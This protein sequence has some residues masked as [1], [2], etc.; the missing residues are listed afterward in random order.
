ML[1]S[2]GDRLGHY[3]VLAHAGA[4]GMGEVYKARDMRLDRTVAIKVLNQ[5]IQRFERE[6]RTV[7]SLNH[8]HICVLHDIGS[9]NGSSYM[10]MEFLEGETLAARIKR[11]RVPLDDALKFAIQIGDALDR[12][13][14][15]GVTHRDI[16][17]GNIMLTRDGAKVLD[18][19]LAKASDAKPT[20]NE[21]TLT[22]AI[23]TEGTVVGTPQYMAPELFE[24]RPA[25]ARSDIWA[26][27]AVLYE[28]VTGQKAFEGKSYS[29]LVGAILSSEPRP[30]EVKPFAPAW[31]ERFVRRCLAKDPE[32]RWQSMGDV[33]LELRHPP[34]ETKAQQRQN[35]WPWVT[36][37]VCLI[38]ALAG[39]AMWLS[40]RNAPTLPSIT[41]I[42]PPEGR[43]FAP[44]RN[45][46][47]S[48]I[49]PDGRTLAFVT[50]TDKG[51]TLLH[52]RPL[53]ALE[54]RSIAGTEN[55]GRPFWSPDSKSVAFVANGKLKR[56]EITG[57][58]PTILCDASAARGGSWSKDGVML[59][60]EPN[61]GLMRIPAE[62]GEPVVVTTVNKKA[63]EQ[64][65]YY[66][67]FLPG[68]RRFLYLVRHADSAKSGIYVASLD[69]TGSAARVLT[70]AFPARYDA[71]TGRL[72]YAE[73][74]S[75]V[76][77][78][79]E[80]NSPRLTGDAGRVVEGID[81]TLA[82]H[83]DFSVSDT[84]TL[85]YKRAGGG[86][87]KQQFVWWD[88]SGKTLGRVGPT[89]DNVTAGYR[90]S[91]DGRR[92]A[93]ASATGSLDLWVLDT[94]RGTIPRLTFR[95]GVSPVWAPDGKQIYYG[96][97]PQ[98]TCRKLADGS[99]EEE[100]AA[101][102]FEGPTSI[103][104]DGSILLLGAGDIFHVP[105]AAGGKPQPLL[106]TRFYEG[107][108]RFSPD[109][110]WIA[111]QSNESGRGEIYVQ[112]YPEPRGKWLA[113]QSGGNYPQWRGDGRELYWVGPDSMLMAAE[114][115]LRE[116]GLETG[117]PEALF[118]V[119]APTG[120]PWVEPSPDGKRFLVL[121]PVGD[122]ERDPP[123]VLIQN[124]AA[125]L[126]N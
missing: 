100:V 39:W 82:G 123:M 66:P 55:A 124:W 37:A 91:P 102:G 18:F 3:E 65:H 42:S 8:P 29:S 13:H 57:G 120:Y 94:T 104:P 63:G 61:T 47:G 56:V 69:E 5:H 15:A 112:S 9:E 64:F 92:V 107:E 22:Q 105:L 35:R 86:G 113:S 48:A 14:R 115:K 116:A 7:A 122:T 46:G 11:G 101:A 125:R 85:F 81:L 76:A 109:G 51:E 45:Q 108:A 19:G 62:G 98:N 73:N 80:L 117:W 68:G 111:Y 16:K 25:D 70:T 44:V 114:V 126:G 99:G 36:A 72:L 6:A 2:S 96:C 89:V 95:G 88:R 43:R 24:G 67:H 38:A 97:P 78:K 87:R 75:L 93:Y 119:A 1:L 60:A 106:Q 52:I 49:S 21:S 41:E 27:G 20:S 83:A 23:S 10:V 28:M 84:G 58:A 33:V 12:A 90:L 34:T 74:G 4:G 53:D 40:M 110:R 59:F 32:E 54:A 79:L 31:L 17:P 77:R 121:E 118:R 103:S 30:M 71:G 26:F 50:A